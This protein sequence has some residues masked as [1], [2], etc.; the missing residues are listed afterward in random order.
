MG[1][2][3]IHPLY[4]ANLGLAFLLELCLPVI[5]GFIGVHFA[6]SLLFKILAGIVFPVLTIIIW[7]KFYAPASATRLKE[8]ALLY[9]KIGIFALAVFVLLV[10]GQPVLAVIFGAA[11]AGN[12]ILMYSNNGNDK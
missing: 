4:L 8:P 10:G 9:A 5:F 3:K 11:S 2:Q 12:L 6:G 1:Q 7:G